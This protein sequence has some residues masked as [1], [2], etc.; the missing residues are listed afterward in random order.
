MFMWKLVTSIYLWKYSYI[1]KRRYCR[2]FPYQMD[3]SGKKL[4]TFPVKASFSDCTMRKIF[5]LRAVRCWQTR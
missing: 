4:Q 1:R 3:K 5:L 2:L